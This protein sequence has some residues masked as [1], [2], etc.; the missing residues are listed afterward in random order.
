[1]SG[2]LVAEPSKEKD[3]WNIFRRENDRWSE[4][5]SVDSIIVGDGYTAEMKYGKIFLDSEHCR[6]E[7]ENGL[8]TFRCDLNKR[9]K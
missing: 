6:V 3:K 1:M 2:D 5:E 4:F 9:K 8:K 7:K